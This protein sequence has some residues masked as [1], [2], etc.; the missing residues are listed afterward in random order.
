MAIVVRVL[1]LVA[2]EACRVNLLQSYFKYTFFGVR[3]TI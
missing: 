1:N 3:K 2:F